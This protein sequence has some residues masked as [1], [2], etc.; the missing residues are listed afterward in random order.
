MGMQLLWN[1]AAADSPFPTPP[2]SSVGL[3]DHPGQPRATASAQK[4]ELA[5]PLT[6]RSHREVPALPDGPQA[7]PLFNEGSQL[8]N[9][10]LPLSVLP[11]P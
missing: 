1:E 8:D 10:L 11:S 5:R 6:L 3:L 7:P 4:Q 2:L 9:L